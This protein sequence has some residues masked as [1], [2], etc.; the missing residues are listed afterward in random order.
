[1]FLGQCVTVSETYGSNSAGEVSVEWLLFYS[2]ANDSVFIPCAASQVIS[3]IYSL[4][5]YLKH[6]ENINNFSSII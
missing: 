2:S 6:L 4:G 5:Y 1:M 3:A